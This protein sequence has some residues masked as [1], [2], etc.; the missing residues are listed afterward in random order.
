MNFN[1]KLSLKSS[2]FKDL[3][4]WF[5]SIE[6]IDTNQAATS[7]TVKS[8]VNF[9]VFID[10]LKRKKKKSSTWLISNFA[11]KTR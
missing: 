2:I 5:N 8:F 10:F 1:L 7:T 6:P 11:S 9:F 4:L 3:Y